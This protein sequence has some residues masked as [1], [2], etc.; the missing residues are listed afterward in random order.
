MTTRV[1]GRQMGFLSY[2]S[3][4]TRR[5]RLCGPST[6]RKQGRS[7]KDRQ[8]PSLAWSF[9]WAMTRSRSSLVERYALL[10]ALPALGNMRHLDIPHP[11]LKL[12]GQ[13]AF[14]TGKLKTKGNAMLATKLTSILGVSHALPH[15]LLD[16]EHRQ[17]TDRQSQSQT[18][19]YGCR[20]SYTAL[21][22][23]SCTLHWCTVN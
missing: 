8:S 2:A 5:K 18:I 15:F 23:L 17:L 7:T 11:I 22:R 21:A 12:D 19:V 20:Y 9:W 16:P 14:M 3:P 10:S 13:K 1:S 6:S 4:T